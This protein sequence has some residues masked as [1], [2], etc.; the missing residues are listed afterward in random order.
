[1]SESGPSVTRASPSGADWFDDDDNLTVASDDVLRD[2]F[3][4]TASADRMWRT[5]SSAVGGDRKALLVKMAISCSAGTSAETNFSE[6]YLDDDNPKSCIQTF[7]NLLEDDKF[8]KQ[9]ENKLRVWARSMSDFPLLTYKVIKANPWLAKQRAAEYE[10]DVQYAAVCF[11][12]ADVLVGEDLQLSPTHKK[13]LKY[14]LR[15]KAGTGRSAV[16]SAE[17]HGVQG[18]DPVSRGVGASVAPD[19]GRMFGGARGSGP[20]A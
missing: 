15:Y 6:R 10:V 7:V 19:S 1:M 5:W 4:P 14:G 17:G 11:D 20:Y 18:S 8:L 3:M 12:Y 16:Y 13:L 2:G 9:R